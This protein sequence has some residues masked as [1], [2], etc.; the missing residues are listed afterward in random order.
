MDRAARWL[1]PDAALVTNAWIS[2]SSASRSP[3]ERTADIQCPPDLGGERSISD[4]SQTIS[5]GTPVGNTD[6][7]EKRRS[8]TFIDTTG[9]RRL[10]REGKSSACPSERITIPSSQDLATGPALA[11]SS[12]GHCAEG[13]H[14]SCLGHRQWHFGQGFS[15]SRVELGNI[16]EAFTPT[17][18]GACASARRFRRRSGLQCTAQPS[19][20]IS[21][22]SRS[23]P[24]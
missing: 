7:S 5:I 22:S 14:L 20:N 15:P 12:P 13:S 18:N 23:V 19:Q 2:M 9:A 10:E 8:R 24:L 16:G 4:H 17:R 11:S 1:P 6:W 21:W 3:D